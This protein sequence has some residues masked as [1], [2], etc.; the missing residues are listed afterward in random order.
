MEHVASIAFKKARTQY[1]HVV[2]RACGGLF[3]HVEIGLG[4]H[5]YTAFMNAGASVV[6]LKAVPRLAPEWFVTTVPMT[7]QQFKTALDFCETKVRTHTPYDLVGA[8]ASVVPGL[9]SVIACVLGDRAENRMFCSELVTEA[10]QKS[11]AAPGAVAT[12]VPQVTHPVALFEAL[13][14]AEPVVPLVL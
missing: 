13:C 9:R 1:E 8:V 2:A 4:V 6:R 10:L 14:A 3:C 7:A 5:A 12:L 11:G